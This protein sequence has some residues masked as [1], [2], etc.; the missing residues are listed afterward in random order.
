MCIKKRPIFANELATGNFKI[1]LKLIGEIDCISV[2][3]PNITIHECKFRVDGVT[4]YIDTS[5]F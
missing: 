5:E 1:N 2:A 4:K 3:N